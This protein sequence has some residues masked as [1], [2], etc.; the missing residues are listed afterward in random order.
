[1][2]DGLSI[3]IFSKCLQYYRYTYKLQWR[4]QRDLRTPTVYTLFNLQYFLAIAFKSANWC[5]DPSI[6]GP[7]LCEGLH[8][9][10]AG[11]LL[12]GRLPPWVLGTMGANGDWQWLWALVSL[13]RVRHWKGSGRRS[14]HRV[15]PVTC[16]VICGKL[17]I[18]NVLWGD[19]RCKMSQA[20]GDICG[21]GADYGCLG[22]ELAR[23]LCS[24]VGPGII[25]LRHCLSVTQM[26]SEKS[27]R[28]FTP[29]LHHLSPPR[30][31]CPRDLG[32]HLVSV[33]VLILQQEKILSLEKR[34]EYSLTQRWQPPC[35]KP[36]QVH[37]S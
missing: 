35:W 1:M 4:S 16:W 19:L 5:V 13:F 37:R 7:C 30:S 2:P 11:Q 14:R 21:P 6:H 9:N 22:G 25:C 27:G 12:S 8:L 31:H 26:F 10:A 36:A 3:W 17:L 23:K 33:T 24:K 15:P 18:F 28:H 34:S 32:C 29:K 20:G